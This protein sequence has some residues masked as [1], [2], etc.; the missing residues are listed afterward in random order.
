MNIII[1][2]NHKNCQKKIK[3]IN[4]LIL[5]KEDKKNIKLLKQI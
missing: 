3:I 4:K 2:N 5:S 1:I